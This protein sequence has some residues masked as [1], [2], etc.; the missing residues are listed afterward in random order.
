[1]HQPLVEQ[2]TRTHDEE[3]SNETAK[4]DHAIAGK[5]ARRLQKADVDDDAEQRP[6]RGAEAS[7][8][9][10]KAG[11]NQLYTENR[12]TLRGGEQA[13]LPDH[14]KGDAKPRS[15]EKK[16]S[17]QRRAEQSVDDQHELRRTHVVLEDIADIAETLDA[18]RPHRF[19]VPHDLI[20]E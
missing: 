8:S 16:K 3:R 14:A 12:D 1:M 15:F 2:P 17:K 9:A 11:R 4:D 18:V 13:V 19:A 10:G 20:A 5:P 7:E 6:K